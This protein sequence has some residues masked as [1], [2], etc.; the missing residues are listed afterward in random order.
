MPKLQG[1]REVI[2]AKKLRTGRDQP[3]VFSTE[4]TKKLYEELGEF[5]TIEFIRAVNRP[6]GT[7]KNY[8]YKIDNKWL[9]TVLA[10]NYSEGEYCDTY[11]IEAYTLTKKEF[12][13][14]V[15]RLSQSAKVPWKIG[16]LVGNIADDKEALEV[17]KTIKEISGTADESLA[18]DLRSS[19]NRQSALRKLLGK[20]WGKLNCKTPEYEY[21]LARYLLKKRN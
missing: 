2:M 8:L 11:T 10:N 7:D 12:G 1:E 15:C 17:L 14:R 5:K 4:I 13:H 3:F 6:P 9:V 18:K 21:N 19:I 16:T 20:T